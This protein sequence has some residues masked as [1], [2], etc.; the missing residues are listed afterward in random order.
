MRS[1]LALSMV[2]KLCLLVA[3][4]PSVGVPL[5][6]PASALEREVAAYQTAIGPIPEFHVI[7]L[8][9]TMVKLSTQNGRGNV[10]HHSRVCLRVELL[11]WLKSP[12]DCLN[13]L[14]LLLPLVLLIGS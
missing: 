9:F 10:L 3:A 12:C 1:L 2:S 7:Q 13:L 14:I 5:E 6:S 4:G 8:V 11:L